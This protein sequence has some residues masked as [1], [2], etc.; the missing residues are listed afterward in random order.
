MNSNRYL[1]FK[2]KAARY[3]VDREIK[4]LLT[5]LTSPDPALAFVGLIHG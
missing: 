4:A 2:V 1:V 3:R 5:E